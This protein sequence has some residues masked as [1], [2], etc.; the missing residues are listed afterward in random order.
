ML[1]TG[2]RINKP[3]TT[4][5]LGYGDDFSRLRDNQQYKENVDDATSSD[6]TDSADSL[7]SI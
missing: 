1:A 4:R 7:T 6:R 2:Q 3:P 5:R